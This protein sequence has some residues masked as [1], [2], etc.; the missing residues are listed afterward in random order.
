LLYIEVPVK[1][2]G[3]ST[4]TRIIEASALELVYRLIKQRSVDCELEA[5]A[6]KQTAQ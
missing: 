5:Q 1:A 4:N 6:A 2:V 3:T